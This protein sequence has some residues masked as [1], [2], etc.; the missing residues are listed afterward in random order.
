MPDHR[1]YVDIMV[2]EGMLRYFEDAD[3]LR[4]QKDLPSATFCRLNDLVLLHG[5]E[6]F[7]SLIGDVYPRIGVGC[8]Q[9]R[10]AHISEVVLYVLY[11]FV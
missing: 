11:I 4:V 6:V 3:Q 9:H 7:Y 10:P 2:D 8:V 5:D 1:Y